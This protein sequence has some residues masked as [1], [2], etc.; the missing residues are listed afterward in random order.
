MAKQTYPKN[1]KLVKTTMQL[2]EEFKL[3]KARRIRE[4]MIDL[5]KELKAAK[6]T[7]IAP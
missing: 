3:E 6:E 7:K 5:S 1:N 2:L 4:A